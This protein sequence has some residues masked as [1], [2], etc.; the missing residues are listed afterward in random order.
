M[1]P[2]QHAR[3]QQRPRFARSASGGSGPHH[4]CRGRAVCVDG[5]RRAHRRRGDAVRSAAWFSRRGADDLRQRDRPACPAQPRICANA[6]NV[7]RGAP[8]LR[9]GRTGWQ[10]SAFPG[11]HDP[12]A[13]QSVMGAVVKPQLLFCRTRVDA[14][15]CAAQS[16]PEGGDQC[17]VYPRLRGKWERDRCT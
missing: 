2:G 7:G 15:L 5:K 9:A 17:V 4:L 12:L 11:G 13:R 8:P 6:R 10:Q 16:P 14:R 1:A 3:R